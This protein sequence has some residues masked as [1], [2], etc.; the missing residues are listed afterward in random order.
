[1]HEEGLARPEGTTRAQASATQ[2]V[3]G[4]DVEAAAVAETVDL[5]RPV[6]VAPVRPVSRKPEEVFPL[7]RRRLRFGAVVLF[8]GFAALFCFQFPTVLRTSPPVLDTERFL[9]W[10]H[11]AVTALLGL[12]GTLLSS[13]QGNTF[14]RLCTAE[15]AVFGLPALLLLAP[16]YFVIL[17][18]AAPPR[19]VFVFSP[20]PWVMLIFVYALFIPSTLL[21]A[22]V[23]LGGIALAPMALVVGLRLGDGSVAQ[24]LSVN[25]MMGILLEIA[26]AAVCSVIGVVKIKSLREEAFRARLFGQYRLGPRIG[27]GGMGEVYLAEHEM[28]KRKCVIKLI[29]ADKLGDERTLARF[30]REVQ[31]TA[32]LSHW[33]TVKILDYGRTA[34]GALYYVM[35]H[36]RGMNLAE[37]VQQRGPLPPERIVHLMTQVCDALR[38][39]HHAR[40]VHRDIKPENIFV[41]QQ[42]GMYDVVKLLDFGLVRPVSEQRDTHL[43]PSGGITGSPLFMSPEQATGDDLAD[44]RID[45]YSL[46]ATSYYLATGA[47]PFFGRNVVELA[48]AHVNQ[49][50][51][52]PSRRNARIASDLEAIVL[53]CLAKSPDARFQNVESLRDALVRCEH[54]GQWRQERAKQWWCEEQAAKRS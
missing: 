12:F 22:S 35:E 31:A 9:F 19:H 50:P 16:Q 27:A 41:G 30:E 6:A 2:R 45:I 4:H 15:F 48:V 23:L 37:M 26:L 33:N 14:F 3:A 1:V 54:Y 36:L 44:P 53:K 8:A 20:V 29:R 51:I 17:K 43:T 42:G 5:T 47:A 46:G 34:D 7:W 18:L 28:L 24:V 39:A 38:E 40:L 11:A 10:S 32:G 13:R 21:R 49:Q 52:P 25:E